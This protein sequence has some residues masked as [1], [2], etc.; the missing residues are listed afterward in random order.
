MKSFAFATCALGLIGIATLN[1]KNS[2]DYEAATLEEKEEWL[3]AQGQRFEKTARFFLKSGGGPSAVSLYLD[4][5]DVSARSKKVTL[6]I[7]V[8]VPYGKQLFVGNV[9][10]EMVPLCKQY[11][12]GGLYDNNV[13]LVA[14]MKTDKGAPVATLTANAAKCDRILDRT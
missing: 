9:N 14:A 2:F 12:R 11:G 1:G 3:T 7:E 5:V 13:T 4:G 6:N 10:E 8:R